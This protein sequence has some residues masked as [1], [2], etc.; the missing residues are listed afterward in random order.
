MEGFLEKIRGQCVALPDDGSFP[1]D[2]AERG[3][4]KIHLQNAWLLHFKITVQHKNRDVAAAELFPDSKAKRVGTLRS[5][6]RLMLLWTLIVDEKMHKL[7]HWQPK[8]GEVL[9]LLKWLP[10][11]VG[12]DLSQW[13]EAELP[14][15]PTL[16]WM[17]GGVK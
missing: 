13:N 6:K 1:Q 14:E 4:F 3:L 2:S 5:V 12:T 7:R 16:I 15:H 8:E 10:S 17:L 11:M 9:Q